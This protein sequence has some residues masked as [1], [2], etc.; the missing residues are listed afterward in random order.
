MAKKNIIDKEKLPIL[1]EEGLSV[2]E[3]AAYFG[4]TYRSVRRMLYVTG[5]KTKSMQNNN[6]YKCSVC[7]KKLAG[8]QAKFCSKKCKIKYYATKQPYNA[9]AQMIKAMKNKIY[10]LAELGVV[11][12]QRCG[13]SD[14]LA[15]L[16]FHH[17]Y[18]HNKNFELTARACAS[19]KLEI[20]LKEARQCEVLCA[21]CHVALH[22]PAWNTD[23]AYS[24][25]STTPH[26]NTTKKNKQSEEAVKKGKAAVDSGLVNV[27]EE[28]WTTR[29][30]N[31]AG[32]S[33]A[34][35]TLFLKNNYPEL[36]KNRFLGAYGKAVKNKNK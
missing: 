10:I 12:C 4:V 16:C 30:A 25:I 23:K 28:G 21:N 29:L 18:P 35:A 19:K 34:W 6:I 22:H 13:Y 9:H 11:G 20:L 1:I 5:F 33:P 26:T 15:A 3:I 2:K 24:V 32:R 31:A 14:N 36:Y 17:K 27:T 7:G 8:K